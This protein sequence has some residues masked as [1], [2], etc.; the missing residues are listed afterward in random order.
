MTQSKNYMEHIILNYLKGTISKEEQIRLKAWTAESTDNQLLFDQ[1]REIWLV[2]MQSDQQFSF[3][4]K[5]A[6]ASFKDKTTEKPQEKKQKSF[7]LSYQLVAAVALIFIVSGFFL[8]YLGTIQPK[9]EVLAYQ[10]IVVP[11]GARSNVRLPDGSDVVLNAGTTLRYNTGFAK[12]N[13]D[14]WLDG[15][16]F[17]D[18]HKLEIPFV[19]HSGTVQ[20]KALGTAFNVRAYSSEKRIETTLVEGKLAINE[21]DAINKSKREVILLPNQKLVIS[22]RQDE[23]SEETITKDSAS[24]DEHIKKPKS[25]VKYEKIDPT[26]DISWKDNEWMIYRENLADLSKRMERRYDIHVIFE[27]DQLKSFRYTGTLLNESL[28]QVLRAMTLVSP[29]HYKVEGKNVVFSVNPNFR[30]NPD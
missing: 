22:K 28:E 1:M 21:I 24:M 29:I 25:I 9:E 18:V 26:P 27:D 13:R 7:S 12:K 3:D 2:S 23:A 17:F 16:G 11:Y 14:L 10:E 20:I 8:F 19:V 30:S 6:F 5:K 4:Y 15:E